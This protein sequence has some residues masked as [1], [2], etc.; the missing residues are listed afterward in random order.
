MPWFTKT[1]N[2]T[3][4]QF[5]GRGRI[6]E[7]FAYKERI[8]KELN[9]TLKAKFEERTCAEL[10][11]AVP[12]TET[13]NVE[14]QKE[15]A[16]LARQGSLAERQPPAGLIQLRQKLADEAFLVGI[17]GEESEGSIVRQSNHTSLQSNSIPI[18]EGVSG[19][20]EDDFVSVF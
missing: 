17:G 10:N 5:R 16:E 3:N 7:K 19:G 13:L 2:Q 20:F 18:V 1:F 8:R 11:E 4:F 15:R 14:V 9:K 12:K 6:D